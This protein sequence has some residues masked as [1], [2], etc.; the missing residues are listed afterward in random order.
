MLTSLQQ[1]LGTLVLNQ[2][3]EQ[4]IE[5]FEWSGMAAARADALEQQ[6]TTLSDRYSVAEDT[7]Q[8]LNQ[9]L[10]DLLRAKDH[11]ET[12]LVANFAQL[13]N[14]KKLKVRN[15]QRLLVSATAD[16]AK[17]KTRFSGIGLSTS[18]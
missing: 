11:H 7:I 3:D 1:R 9:Q 8:K 5:L 6:V 13:L 14:E 4:A 15:Q 18:A 16:P 12:H 10:E 2:D 17:G